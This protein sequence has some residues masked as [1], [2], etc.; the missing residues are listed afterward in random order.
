MA[1]GTLDE[2]LGEEWTKEIKA[3]KEEKRVRAHEAAVMLIREIEGPGSWREE[4]E[5]LKE[6]RRLKLSRLIP[7]T[8]EPRKTNE[9][10]VI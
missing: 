1:V 10:E 3:L 6:R 5:V 4:M 2:R 7:G 9:L 8:P